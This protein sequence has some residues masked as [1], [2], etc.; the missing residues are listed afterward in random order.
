MLKSPVPVYI[1]STA[2]S[3]V[4]FSTSDR[5]QPLAAVPSKMMHTSLHDNSHSLFKEN[6]ISMVPPQG[7]TSMKFVRHYIKSNDKCLFNAKQRSEVPFTIIDSVFNH[8]GLPHELKYLAVI[9]SE[10]KA[11]AVSPVGAKGPWQLMPATAHIF[12]LRTNRQVDERMNYYKSTRAAARY[13][14]DLYHEFKDWLLVLAAYNGGPAPV[15]RAIHKSHNRN[16]W[17][18]QQWLPA[19]SRNHVKKFIA[20]DYYFNQT[21]CPVKSAKTTAAIAKPI[22]PNQPVV[23]KTETPDQKFSRL[24]KES[25]QSLQRSQEMLVNSN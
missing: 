9:E 6:T 20:T 11:S 5:R 18:L 19:E 12:G 14:K 21:E 2:F 7:K 10:L 25:A 15:I 3:L 17:A 1:C 16:F 13:L 24:M 4:M 8:Y 22:A 23:A